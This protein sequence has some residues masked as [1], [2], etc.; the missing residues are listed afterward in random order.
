MAGANTLKFS[1][2]NFDTEVMGAD[3]PVLVDFWAE[4]CGPCKQLG[5]VLDE[6]ATEYDGKVK[7][8]KVNIDDH[9][10]LAVQLVATP[11]EW[12]QNIGSAVCVIDW[13]A[14]LRAI[15]DSVGLICPSDDIKKRFARAWK[16]KP[17]PP[18]IQ[19]EPRD[20]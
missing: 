16:W 18:P 10:N 6:L 17:R 11:A 8:A 20:G 9:Q 19:P 1:D 3:K 2:A 13:S 14:N 12:L 5:P 15:F 7:I 4:W